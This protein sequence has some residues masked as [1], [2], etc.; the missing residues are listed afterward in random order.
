M[1]IKKIFSLILLLA[2]FSPVFVHAALAGVEC[3]NTGSITGN[4]SGT[5]VGNAGPNSGGLTNPV[6]GVP[7]IACLFYRIVDFVMSLSYV[8]IAFFLLLSGFKFVTAQGSDEKL[9]DAK[10][11]FWYTVIGALILI[12][13]NTIIQVVQGIIK[14]IQS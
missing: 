14:G 11:T 10:K 9:T 12:G 5:V 8:V 7:S 3:N 6:Q 4:G 1:N 2:L 13:A